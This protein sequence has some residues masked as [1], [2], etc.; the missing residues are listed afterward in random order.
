ML[1]RFARDIHYLRVSVTDR[2]NL[3]CVYCMPEE[4]VSLLSHEEILTFEEM[5]KLIQVAASLGIR[6]VRLTGGEPLVRKDLLSFVAA[7]KAIPGIEEVALTTNG[8]LLPQYAEDLK[9]AG[10]DRV[11]ISLDTMHPQR[12]QEITRNGHIDE[13]WSGIEA[14]LEAQFHPV[15]VNV[16]VMGGINDDEIADFACL[17]KRWPIHVRFI[18]IMPIGEGEASYRGHFVSIDEMKEKLIESGQK[19]QS[20]EGIKGCGPATYYTLPSAQGTVGFISAISKHFCG[21]CN[22]LRLTA[23]GQLRPCLHAQKEMDLKTPLRMGATEKK[24]QLLFR[25][26]IESKPEQHCLSDEGWA[27]Q[28]RIMSQIGG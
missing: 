10:L 13:V 12:F 5:E 1:D 22:R 23:E 7:V 2:C 21:T 27:G 26:A 19:L 6:R 14:A 15:K 11:N 16:V 4:G 8:I 24:L 28:G 9:K 3:R 18:E 17:T 25:Q 20:H